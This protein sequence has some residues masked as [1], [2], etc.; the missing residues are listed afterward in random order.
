LII[1]SGLFNSLS[2][3]SRVSEFWKRF[4]TAK[5]FK[6]SPGNPRYS[7]ELFCAA[8]T[9]VPANRIAIIEI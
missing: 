7:S 8:Y 6:L 4:I 5:R 9:L 3:A 1:D 2:N